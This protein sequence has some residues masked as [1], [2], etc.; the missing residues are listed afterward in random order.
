MNRYS[1]IP[2]SSFL[3][4]FGTTS[5]RTNEFNKRIEWQLRLLD[6]FWQ[7][8]EN[9]G[10][11]WEVP[12]EGQDDIY[13]IKNRYYDWLVENGFTVGDDKVK[14]KAAREKTSG[15]VD[16]GLIDR[17][18]RLTDV[19]KKLLEIVSTHGYE[20]KTALGITKDSELYLGQLIKMN[21]TN[22]GS[23]VRPFLIVVYLI[24][25]LEYLTFDEFKYLLP[26][27]INVE[28]TKNILDS[29]Q[30]LRN[31]MGRIDDVIISRL[32]DRPNY[33]EGLERFVVNPFS[34]DLLL[35][36][37]MNRKSPQRYDKVYCDLYREMHAVYMEGNSH[38]VFPLFMV[39]RKISGSCS[40]KWKHLLFRT[41]QAS[42]IKK[43]P[44]S[45]IKELPEGVLETDRI[46]KKFFY[47][48]M[49]LYKAKATLEDY[50]DLNRRYL[51]LSNCFIFE[52][53][54]VKLDIVPRQFFK[55]V[56]NELYEYAY[57]T[58][59]LL[60][61]YCPLSDISPL[62]AFNEEK[63]ISGINSEFGTNV[64][65]ISEAYT[66][67]ERQR[68]CRFNAMLDKRFSKSTLIRLLDDFDS[69]NDRNINKLVT[70]NADVP[71]IFEYI[72]GIIWYNLSERKGKILDYMKLSLDA[73]FLPITHAAGGEADIVYEYPATEHYPQHCLLLEATLSDNTNQR[74]MEMEPVSRHL[75]DHLLRTGNLNSYCVFA[76][77]HL[78]INVISDFRG[79][80]NYYYCN[81]QDSDNYIIGMKIIPLST[82]DLRK[83]VHWDKTYPELY[84]YFEQAF[85][86]SEA[87]PQRWYDNYVDIFN[88][89]IPES[90]RPFA[91]EGIG[92]TV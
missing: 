16:M 31:G 75:G 54:Q 81:S 2:Y 43:N 66:E 9:Q 65:D 55:P 86:S 29:I 7:K 5:F 50:F 21:D 53:S 76:S 36:V 41:A 33:Y 79:R 17:E 6:E 18:H 51:N 38:R 69:R 72:L 85:Q 63:V 48:T 61:R 57:E 52:E 40:R 19:G 80:K 73:N 34:D 45:C 22:T 30:R 70:E 49:H 37:S 82:E 91:A 83:I 25:N 77:S 23:V 44:L 20:E 47:L 62:L 13:E 84:N 28:T 27:C 90:E 60:Y 58:S 64:S 26:L 15:L 68:Y 87:H 78:H 46:F 10:L 12:V 56:A 24:S 71:T 35:S 89:L 59:S 67:V 1:K 4:K 39:V 8:P 42:A 92:E 88:L 3:W 11:G 14:Y 32:L 74:R